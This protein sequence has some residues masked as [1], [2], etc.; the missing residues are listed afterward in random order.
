MY[1][2][3]ICNNINFIEVN[4]ILKQNLTNRTF[5]LFEKNNLNLQ[6]NKEVKCC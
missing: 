4:M 5:G 3:L 6:K 1:S 2:I